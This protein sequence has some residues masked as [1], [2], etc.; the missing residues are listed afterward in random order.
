MNKENTEKK[1]IAKINFELD[2]LKSEEISVSKLKRFINSFENGY[3]DFYFDNKTIAD[4]LT[5]YHLLWGNANLFNNII[6]SYTGITP[7]DIQR[8][9]KKYLNS[10][11]CITIIY[12]PEN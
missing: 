4:Q 3:T 2:K 12:Y 6:E 5:N 7:A 9:A 11:N 10:N 1:L 8:V